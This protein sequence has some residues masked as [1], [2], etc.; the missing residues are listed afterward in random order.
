M[1]TSGPTPGWL[2]AKRE[3]VSV[4]ATTASKPRAANRAPSLFPWA[5]SRHDFS[6]P[7]ACQAPERRTSRGASAPDFLMASTMPM[8][9][10]TPWAREEGISTKA[11]EWHTRSRTTSGQYR[12]V[13]AWASRTRIQLISRLISSGVHCP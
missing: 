12:L 7:S 5:R 8:M 10:S 9:R 1:N 11:S 4:R 6:T 3:A 2:V 13:P